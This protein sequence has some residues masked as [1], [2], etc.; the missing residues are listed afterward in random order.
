MSKTLAIFGCGYLGSEL[1]R[2]GL[3][4]GWKVSALT[5]NA[6]TAATLRDSGV[7]QV[8]EAELSS[9]DWHAALSPEVD[10]LVNC[11][12]AASDDVAGYVRSY[13]EGQDSLMRWAER[14]SV[15]SFV[16]TSSTSVY[17]QRGARLVDETSDSVGV[18]DRAGLL[19][20][21]ENRG[22]AGGNG[23]DR[24]FVLRLAGLYGPGRHL[25]ADKVRT[26]E[27]F[28]GNGD[29]I[30][31]LIHRDDAA[32]AVFSAL[33]ADAVNV[34][35]IYNVSDGAP[36]PRREIVEWLAGKLGV[37]SPGF[38][39]DDGE[40]VPNRKVSNDRIRNEL[41]WEPAYASY[42]AGFEAIFAEG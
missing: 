23:I 11:V 39:E 32:S 22:Y 30:L 5:R 37:D 34:G 17:P 8:I 41:G 7:P 21:A 33:E 1:A 27:G 38:A 13:V 35:R 4:R 3:A 42:R 12:G 28:S 18:S 26:G 36:A 40:D 25:L 10:Y 16:F 20:A 24:C 14:G 15:G 2:Q 29:R 6:G 19:L 9:D 31:N